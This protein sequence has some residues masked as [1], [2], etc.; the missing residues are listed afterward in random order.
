[1]PER[2]KAG[3]KLPAFTY[4]TPYVPQ[5]DFYGLLAQ[6]K[7]LFLVFLRNFGHP[8]ARH[9]IMEYIKDSAELH[10]ARL[11]C[12][13]R[14]KPQVI[15]RAIPQGKMPYELIC[16]AEGVLYEHFGVP[17]VPSRFKSYSLAALKIL[18]QA[19]KQGYEPP[20]DEP[21]QLPLTLL[22]GREGEVLFAHYGQS[23]TDLPEN[24]A[25][26]ERVAAAVLQARQQESAASE[27]EEEDDY[28]GRM[29]HLAHEAGW[30]VEDGV[31]PDGL[32]PRSDG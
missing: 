14:T 7:P 29:Q 21:Q 26:L 30:G 17:L 28:M 4:D 15:G 8:I 11:A 2:L 3:D 1:M 5:A 16:D 20:K 10:S 27:P 25:A 32:T 24:C 13:V 19:K 18:K 22:V 31:E 12:V 9:Y 23:V 6:D